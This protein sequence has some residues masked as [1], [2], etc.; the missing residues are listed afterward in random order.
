[1]LNQRLAAAR[2]V[3]DQLFAAERAIDAALTEVAA[4]TASVPRAAAQ[5]NVA[6]N[7]GHG[8]L[9]RTVAVTA[10]L[11]QARREIIATHEELAEAK[12]RVGLRTVAF[13]GGAYKG[14]PKAEGL[15]V[16]TANAA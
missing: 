14:P 4:L 8:A 6:L 13:G 12:D 16:V 1:M 3:A 15:S 7:I 11:V 2:E 10:A 5:A 9:E